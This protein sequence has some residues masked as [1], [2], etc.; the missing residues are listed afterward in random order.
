MSFLQWCMEDGVQMATF[1]AFSTENW[2]RSAAEISTLMSIFTEN[3]DKL[4]KEA[5]ARDIR[6]KILSTGSIAEVFPPFIATINPNPIQ[7]SSD[8]L[9][10]SSC[11]STA[12]RERRRTAR[13]SWPT[14]VCPTDPGRTSSWP[15]RNWLKACLRGSSL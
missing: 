14:S 4:R 6:V 7:T 2:N 13:S 11:P 1:Y 15:L 12:C 5:V 8:S 3:A 10:M 9:R